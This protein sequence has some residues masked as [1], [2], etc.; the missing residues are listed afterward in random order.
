[1]EKKDS[2]IAHEPGWIK[3]FA[4]LKSDAVPHFAPEQMV[5]CGNCRRRN[6]P[7]R[8]DCFYC[9]GRLEINEKNEKLIRPVLRRLENWEKG[10]N[11]ACFS[12]PQNDLSLDKSKEIS[13][14][15]GIEIEIFTNLIQFDFPM[16]VARVET[17]TEAEIVAS[18]LNEYNLTSYI[19]AD[20]DLSPEKPPLRVRA[21][22]FADELKF[23]LNGSDDFK[24]I[25]RR[26]LTIFVEGRIFE[27]KR[28]ALEPRSKKGETGEV[29]E[30]SEFSDDERVLDCY[31]FE[32]PLGYR[33]SAKSF[34]FS[35]LGEKKSWLANENFE[36]LIEELK[37]SAPDAVFNKNYKMA[38]GL[39]NNIWALD[40][41]RDSIGLKHAGIGKI[42]LGK[43]LTAG[44]QT[45]FN[46]YSRMLAAWEKQ[47][48]QK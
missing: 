40:E 46:R 9:G 17:K 44:N 32:N 45:Q 42:N 10:F 28:E 24:T 8:L 39:L 14:F 6:P 7:T 36:T 21:V 34:D 38:R 4:D 5:E 26:G 1:M 23:R 33:I 47:K 48:R 19:V 16:P 18:R 2:L 12:S 3:D 11:V 37:Q 31:D 15:L 43:V 30:S 20:K 25:D 29:G 27:S 35:C 13:A 22:S 41:R